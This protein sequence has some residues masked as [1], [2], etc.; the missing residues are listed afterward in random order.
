M[1]NLPIYTFKVDFVKGEILDSFEEFITKVFPMGPFKVN[2][3]DESGNGYTLVNSVINYFIEDY[4]LSDP[5]FMSWFNVEGRKFGAVLKEFIENYLKYGWNRLN[6]ANDN[7]Y[8][9]FEVFKGNFTSKAYLPT[10]IVSKD[11]FDNFMAL[12]P[13]FLFGSKFSNQ[14]IF[15]YILPAFIQD[16]LCADLGENEEYNKIAN[17]QIGLA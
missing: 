14:D 4:K 2:L 1:E 5:H 10:T 7:N 8:Y 11:L 15:K 13:D 17:Y 3:I 12:G 16:L 9:Q 6:L